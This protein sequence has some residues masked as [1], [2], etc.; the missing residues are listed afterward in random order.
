MS[1][2]IRLPIVD[3]KQ[4]SLLSDISK[5][6][7]EEA[8]LIV[9]PEKAPIVLSRVSKRLRAL[10][11]D[12]MTDYQEILHGPNAATERRELISCLTTNVT[13][14]F[15]EKHHFE[16]LK[17]HMEGIRERA[18]SGHEVRIW[19]A[20][21]S[22]GQEPISIAITILEAIPEAGSL[23][24]RILASDIDQHVLKIAR[25]A[26]YTASQTESITPTLLKKYFQKVK[27]PDCSNRYQVLRSVR[28][29]ISYRELNLFS[30]WPIRKQY[31]AIFCRNVVIYFDRPSQV[32]L[33]K[34]FW[35]ASRP[36]GLMFIGHS[37]RIPLEIS[38]RFL[39]IGT[40]TYVR[41][42]QPTSAHARTKG[43]NLGT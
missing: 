11:L 43:E 8:G 36:G 31:D 25:E 15:R 39:S 26:T 13:S 19:S 1:N 38:H 29:L 42:A 16:Y 20:G 27:N 10:K 12:S 37:E 35:D 6:A 18:K 32:H 7:Y 40:T 30:S 17:L 23:D 33:W 3:G 24:I 41:E 2:D 28:D 9:V 14:F 5:I 22:S 34:R 4:K 21:C